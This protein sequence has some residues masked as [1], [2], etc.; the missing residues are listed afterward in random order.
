MPYTQANRLLRLDTPLGDDVLLLE[1]F[2]GQ[3]GISQIF[4]FDLD[5][6]TEGDPIDFN[7]IIGE[8]VT[9]RVELLDDKERFFN[10]F[11]NRFAQTGSETGVIHY[12]AEMV[13]WL[14]FLTRTADCRIFQNKKVPDILEQIFKD[15]GFTDYKLDLQGTYDECEY[16]VQYRETDFNFVSRLMEQY[17][18]Y[19]FFEH[20]EDK[21]TLVLGDSPSVHQAVPNQPKANFEPRGSGT[22][23]K[24]VITSLEFEKEIR[25]GK[26]SHTDF[27]FKTPSTKLAA[28]EASVINIGGNDKYEIYDY[29]GEYPKKANGATL[30]KIRMQEEE[31]QHFIITGSSSCRAFTSGYKFDLEDY[32][33]DDLNQSYLLTDSQHVGSMGDTYTPGGATGGEESYSNT[34]VCIPH[35]VPFR[36]PQV[37]PK[38][39]VQGPQTAV[40]VGPSGEE[41]YS[42]EFGRVKIQFHWDR[43]GG[44]DENSSCWV[45]VSQLWAGKEWGAI[46]IPRIGQ[47]VIVEFLEGDPDRPIITGRV[48]NAE[49]M[50]P[51]AL[52]DNQTQS[53]IKTRSTKGGGADN[54]NEIRFEDK[55]GS[56]EMYLHAEKDQN[57]MVENDQ[58]IEVG[59]DR[60]KTVKNN[61]LETIEVNKTISV[62]GNHDETITGT[63]TQSIK[64]GMTQIVSKEKIETV[65][66]AKVLT[67]GAAYQVSVGAVMNET[68]GGAKTEEVGAFKGEAVGGSKS[69]VI[70]GSKSFSSGKDLTETVGKNRNVIISKDFDEKIGGKHLE[71]VSKEYE[72]KAKKIQLFA[73]EELVLKTGKA[74]II[75]KKNGDI[76]IK[77]KK[78]NIKGSAD[79]II[80]GSKIKEN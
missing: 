17:G 1:G 38:P 67:I 28:E 6:M 49:H 43:E 61:Q 80:K 58:G 25:P 35:S 18:I 51:Y 59:N 24:D 16:C 57:T 10:G 79:V 56:E 2:T 4:K 53:G 70:G 36:P 13:P 54:F 7:K 47:E 45:R 63:M 12:R 78:I 41:I 44:N 20:E 14:W 22:Q 52:P 29:P 34:F 76:T 15:L 69:E 62:G 65:Q 11:I 66:L 68:V 33:P 32:K 75:M 3:E 50:P 23:D 37:T 31:A 71:Q 72:L 46:F 77:G 60:T 5:L 55:K 9:I 27:N 21:H 39:L 26:F 42:D 48:Y 8:Q 74:E 64:S 40:V 30:A 73:E 19:Y